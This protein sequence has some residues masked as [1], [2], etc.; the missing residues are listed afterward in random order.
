MCTLIELCVLLTQIL[1][2]GLRVYF[3]CYYYRAQLR[4][5]ALPRHLTHEIVYSVVCCTHCCLHA[6]MYTA[7]VPIHSHL[8][9]EDLL[10]LM[11]LLHLKS[12]SKYSITLTKFTWVERF[13]QFILWLYKHWHCYVFKWCALQAT[14]KLGSSALCLMITTVHCTNAQ[15]CTPS[16]MHTTHTFFTMHTHVCTLVLTNRSAEI[17]SPHSDNPILSEKA[18][19][20]RPARPGRGRARLTVAQR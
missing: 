11:K 4:Q 16:Y 6:C 2:N 3:W 18:S 14:D 13:Q 9:V 10:R 20:L 12:K 7:T 19:P 17:G 15:Q 5:Q 1:R 8:S